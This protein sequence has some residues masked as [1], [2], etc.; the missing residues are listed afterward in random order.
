MQG[1]DID[2]DHS[3]LSLGIEFVK[4]A[5]LTEARVV[6]DQVDR[7]LVTQPRLD[8]G[9]RIAI[10]EVGNEDL[11]VDVHFARKRLEPFPVSS[12]D[13]QPCSVDRQL[14]CDRSADAR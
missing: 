8:V 2:L 12:H 4:R 9:E 5:S 11:T 10:G 1:N 13:H 7:R 6:H 3:G 14:L